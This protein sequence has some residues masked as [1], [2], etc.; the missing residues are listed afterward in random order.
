EI[1]QEVL[2]LAKIE[3]Q[4]AQTL[5]KELFLL[6]GEA[7][8][9]LGGEADFVQIFKETPVFDG[10]F[11]NQC[12]Q[13]RIFSAFQHFKK[14]NKSFKLE[15]W[16]GIAFHLP[17]AKHGQRI[18]TQIFAHETQ[19]TQTGELLE[20][21]LGERYQDDKNYLKQVGRS[22][23]YK[24][25]VNKHIAAG[26]R[27]SAEI[28]NMYTASIFM[29]FL[30]KIHE[31]LQKNSNFA[32]LKVGFIAYGSGSKAKVFEGVI[33]EEA[34]SVLKD[35]PLFEIL[36]DRTPLD[37]TTYESWHYQ[38]S[39]KSVPLSGFYLQKVTQEGERI[40]AET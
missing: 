30:S 22:N 39:D 18:F 32:Q 37:Y 27:A 1:I 26:Q 25:F 21:E 12:Y 5:V 11:S 6:N 36:E 9:I 2:D 4:S 23:T 24:S 10:Q 34:A 28:G 19:G 29:S 13:D 17:Y 31:I 8:E 38:K 3:D 33:C 35:R 20:Q 16:S 14:E 7:G 15:D 40:Y